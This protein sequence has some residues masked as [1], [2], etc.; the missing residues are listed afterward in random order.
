VGDEWWWDRPDIAGTLDS[1]P[2][3]RRPAPRRSTARQLDGPFA[4]HSI[5]LAPRPPSRWRGRR[6]P[7]HG[8]HGAAAR[9][10]DAAGQGYYRAGDHQLISPVLVG[11]MHPP[12]K[13]PADL[14][15]IAEVVDGEA[16]AGPWRQ[17]G[18]TMTYPA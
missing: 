14:Y 9:D 7:R 18:C 5:R 2:A 12:G 8:R 1:S 3:S 4:I 6:W 17:S 16:A 11:Q 13:D 10:R 15:S